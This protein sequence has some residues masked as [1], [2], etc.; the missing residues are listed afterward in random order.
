MVKI[1]NKNTYKLLNV[2]VK[3]FVLVHRNSSNSKKFFFS[4]MLN[5]FLRERFSENMLILKLIANKSYLFFKTL[6]L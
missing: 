6:D 1:Q 3:I 2:K 4:P 5:D